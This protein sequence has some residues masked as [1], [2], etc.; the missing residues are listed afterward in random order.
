MN[1][2]VIGALRVTIAAC[3]V[4]AGGCTLDAVVFSGNALDAYKIP[5]T[6]IPDSLR[7]EV[8]FPSGS[9]TLYGY[10]IRQPGPAPRLTVIYSH[11]KGENLARDIEWTHAE[12]LWQA[13][14]DVLTYDYRG[15]GRSTGTSEDERT[16]IADAQ[17]ALAFT[18]A[19]P[20][21]T[22]GRIVSYGHSLGSAPGIALAE[23][24]PGLRALIVE[25]G[26][27]TGQAMAESADPLGFPVQWLLRQPM[28][29]TDRIARVTAPV[30][31]MHGDADALIPVAQGRALY[32]AA[33]DPKQLRIVNGAGH[34]EVQK[35]LG[36]AVFGA[37]V[38]T[39]T[40]AAVP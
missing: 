6:I 14:F 15:F 34:D 33:H 22:L 20:G 18:L 11:G 7:R 27:A 32:A 31:V 37:L 29:N 23:A 19:Q 24:T 5:A 36:V 38:R 12:F 10:W 25:S 2:R 21:V 17:A 9:E 13:G 39:F 40:N 8:T 26:F 1:G 35:G 4:A 30:L 16:L 28:R 3:V